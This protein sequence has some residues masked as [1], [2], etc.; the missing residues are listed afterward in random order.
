MGGAVGGA[1][2]GFKYWAGE[3]RLGGQTELSLRARPFNTQRGPPTIYL[4]FDIQ[5]NTPPATVRKLLYNSPLRDTA[6]PERP[7]S[8]P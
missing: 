8:C 5:R 2:F 7:R 1:K 4:V 3:R 6:C